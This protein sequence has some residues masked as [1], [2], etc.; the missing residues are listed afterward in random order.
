[1]TDNSI[2]EQNTDPADSS[3]HSSYFYGMPLRKSG[4]IA[5][6]LSC[7]EIL[8]L[9]KEYGQ[10]RLAAVTSRD[11][12]KNWPYQHIYVSS[13]AVIKQ[14]SCPVPGGFD[15]ASIAS[16]SDA[17]S[18]FYSKET[19]YGNTP[20]RLKKPATDNPA[21]KPPPWKM[22]NTMSS[23][24]APRNSNGILPDVQGDQFIPSEM[25]FSGDINEMIGCDTY[26]LQRKAVVHIG[27][28][29]REA[30][31]SPL[32]RHALIC[33]LN[34]AH[35]WSCDDS[36]YWREDGVLR[37][38]YINEAT[39]SPSGRYGLVA[40]EGICKV[41]CLAAGA[42][43]I[44]QAEIVFNGS[45]K[46]IR[47]SP[48]ERA[49][50]IISRP[51]QGQTDTFALYHCN[52]DDSWERICLNDMDQDVTC[53]FSPCSNHIL[54]TSKKGA[55]LLNICDDGN[56]ESQYSFNSHG[57]RVE[58][59]FSKAGHHGVMFTKSVSG[60]E[61]NQLTII[62]YVGGK[63]QQMG[64]FNHYGII[65]GAKF[66]ESARH[67]AIETNDGIIRI[68]SVN[69]KG[70]Y[71]QTKAFSENGVESESL[72]WQ[73]SAS[74]DVL[75]TLDT[76]NGLVQILNYDSKEKEK[77]RSVFYAQYD[78]HAQ[79]CFSAIPEANCIMIHTRHTVYVRH[80]INKA[81]HQ[82][83]QIHS[84]ETIEG[85]DISP[86]GR[87]VLTRHE[88]KNGLIGRIWGFDGEG[89]AVV[90]ADIYPPAC[91]RGSYFSIEKVVFSASEQRLRL[92]C[93]GFGAKFATILWGCDDN[94]LWTERGV[95][96]NVG[97]KPVH[98]HA[99]LQIMAYDE[100]KKN[101]FK[102]YGYD[103]NGQ[104]CKKADGSH[105][106]GKVETGC[107]SRSGRLLLTCDD[108]GTASIWNISVPEI[109]V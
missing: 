45:L 20:N 46:D 1:M 99:M 89:N 81:T 7:A 94:G 86:S 79:A 95:V 90:K 75:F 108:D 6:H 88:Q 50:A 59:A 62:G 23:F 19:C 27:G 77:W 31:F 24:T 48:T 61:H 25:A 9:Q 78:R 8:A 42:G 43:W 76:K 40:G 16:I 34:E 32:E 15:T 29:I 63:W 74:E 96:D 55:T 103:R 39:F 109:E 44:E 104:W 58:A 13:A 56:I 53:R 30:K 82:I 97:E 36:G 47:F 92:H 28:A 4:D 51:H 71:D 91:A 38:S 106:T 54:V 70:H 18:I 57:K 67:L 73:I 10:L 64:F 5:T 98:S 41:W 107:F 49:L 33:S 85:A 105:G 11:I 72:R 66:T 21:D 60:L 100:D 80:D 84:K 2:V 68:W 37:C 26:Q 102:I 3:G 87:H 69:D 101:E 93:R 22:A 65:W 35:C 52:D 12:K 83:K 14:N 17:I